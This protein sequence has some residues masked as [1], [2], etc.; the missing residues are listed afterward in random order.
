VRLCILFVVQGK[1]RE[2]ER[3]PV[4]PFPTVILT[5][6]NKSEQLSW[7]EIPASSGVTNS[8]E[9]LFGNAANF[10]TNSQPNL[11]TDFLNQATSDKFFLDTHQQQQK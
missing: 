10:G 9:C 7:R 6:R 11:T 4:L 5:L 1:E 2:R 3:E 8:S